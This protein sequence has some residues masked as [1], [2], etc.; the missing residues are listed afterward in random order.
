M[1]IKI[2][3]EAEKKKEI[4]FKHCYRCGCEFEFS[5]EDVKNTFDDQRE[6]Y[7]VLYVPCP[8]CGDTT[9]VEKKP[10]RYE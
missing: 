8:H 5:M 2:T 1:A 4:Y 3:K 7:V 10:I 9:G 6:G